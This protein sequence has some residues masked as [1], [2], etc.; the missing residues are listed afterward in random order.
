MSLW[1]HH[2]RKLSAVVLLACAPLEPVAWP[3]PGG[4]VVMDGACSAFDFVVV[5]VTECAYIE[6]A[7]SL[8]Y[9]FC[10]RGRYTYC[11]CADG[12]PLPPRYRR[13]LP[14]GGRVTDASAR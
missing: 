2:R 10:D 14:D 1:V 4:G 8:A 11:G 13:V 5:P 6:C 12:E 7:G 3:V 9:A